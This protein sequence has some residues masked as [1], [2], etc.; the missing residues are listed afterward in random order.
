MVKKQILIIEDDE[1]IREVLQLSLEFE[2][3]EVL[4]AANGSEGLKK[5]GLGVNPNL[6]LLDLMMPIMNGWE[7]IEKIELDETNKSI[8]II[9]ISAFMEKGTH[10]KCAAFV[11]KPVDLTTLLNS[12]K[13]HIQ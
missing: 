7:F 4:T 3:Y 12:I 5:L 13:E 6:I 2:G 8:P 1:N 11:S 9:V 10:V